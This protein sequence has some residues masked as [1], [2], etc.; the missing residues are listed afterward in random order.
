M[1]LALVVIVIGQAVPFFQHSH[2]LSSHT[3]PSALAFWLFGNCL[4]QAGLLD[5]IRQMSF[6]S[7]VFVFVLLF[8]IG[9]AYLLNISVSIGDGRIGN[10]I[11]FYP[12]ATAW[13]MLLMIVC[14]SFPL[15]A[16]LL[17][18]MG[19]NSLVLMVWHMLIPALTCTLYGVILGGTAVGWA[20]VALR[21]LNLSILSIIVV[22]V[23]R[24]APCL[25]GRK[26]WISG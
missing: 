13:S 5:R 26:K 1:L 6:H 9:T 8:L 21:I 14:V 12:S 2:F 19:R 23:D 24:Y 10:P 20:K 4:A 7:R 3:W 17:E 15:H 11:I 16:P 25:S 18:F 22:V